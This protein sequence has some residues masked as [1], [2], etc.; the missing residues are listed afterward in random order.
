MDN[1][2]EII[3]EAR[4]AGMQVACMMF[5][6]LIIVSLLFGLFIYESFQLNRNTIEAVQ[7]NESGDNSINQGVE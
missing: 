3:K 4:K 6:A 2:I 7:T 1:T 5:G